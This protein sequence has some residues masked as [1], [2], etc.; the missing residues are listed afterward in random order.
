M[1]LPT[2]AFARGACVLA[3]TLIAHGY[4]PASL[5]VRSRFRSTTWPR[6]SRFRTSMAS[7]TS[8]QARVWSPTTARPFRGFHIHSQKAGCTSTQARVVASGGCKRDSTR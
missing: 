6:T 5:S 8:T 4:S 7:C 1:R 2:E 3:A